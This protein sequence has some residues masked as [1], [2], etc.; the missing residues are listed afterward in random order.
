MI[1]KNEIAYKKIVFLS[2]KSYLEKEDHLGPNCKF[3]DLINNSDDVIVLSGSINGLIGKLFNKG[4]IIEIEK[5]YKK[6]KDKFKND[7][8]I[9]IQRHGD[10]NERSFE[11]LN[12]NLIWQV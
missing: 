12:L 7:F 11:L 1:A 3:D 5:I 2:S 8:Y 10:L 6:L 9:E 4:K